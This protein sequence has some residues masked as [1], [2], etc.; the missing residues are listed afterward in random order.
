MTAFVL[1]ASIT[2]AWS[3]EDEA[4]SY[5]ESLLNQMQNGANASVPPHWPVEVLNVLVL[6]KKKGRITEEKLQSFLLL[7]NSLSIQI[8]P[9]Y[10]FAQLNRIRTLAEKH[11]LTAYDAAYL[12]LALR[13]RE[14]IASLDE[15]LRKAAKA[16]GVQLI[17][18]NVQ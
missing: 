5:T 13:R 12:E 1:D 15:D 10:D 2:L 3:F 7:L 18:E 8:A 6:G 16:E 17:A 11:K 14:P 4:S 9:N